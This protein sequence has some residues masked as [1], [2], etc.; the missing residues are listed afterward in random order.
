[1]LHEKSEKGANLIPYQTTQELSGQAVMKQTQE[2]QV[3]YCLILKTPNFVI[4]CIFCF[5]KCW[6]NPF[7]HFLLGGAISKMSFDVFQHHRGIT[8]IVFQASSFWIS[9]YFAGHQRKII[10]VRMPPGPRRIILSH[11]L[12]GTNWSCYFSHHYSLSL[13]PSLPL[14]A[15]CLL[16][17]QFNVCLNTQNGHLSMEPQVYLSIGDLRIGISGNHFYMIQGKVHW[18]AQTGLY[19]FPVYSVMLQL[20]KTWK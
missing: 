13:P 19:T 17:R 20:R 3:F 4:L 16:K 11:S 1:M 15:L 5:M 9:Y 8:T 10:K 14:S 12:S 6:F 2:K 18:S 7:E